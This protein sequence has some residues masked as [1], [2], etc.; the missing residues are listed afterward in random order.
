MDEPRHARL[1]A[2][3]GEVIR[4][5]DQALEQ[6]PVIVAAGD[7]RRAMR[8]HIEI[9]FPWLPVLAVEELPADRRSQ[10]I[11]EIPGVP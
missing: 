2:A 11:A 5:W 7:V 1:V 10:V 8:R 4:P 6:S 3:V 9:E